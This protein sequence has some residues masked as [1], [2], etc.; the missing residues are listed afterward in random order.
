MNEDF[1][2]GDHLH[3]RLFLMFQQQA[4]FM[5]LLNE[6]RD[7]PE[8]PVNITDKKAQQQCRDIVHCTVEE[9][10]EAL[11]H[12][13]N[14]KKHRATDVPQVD[15]AEFIEEVVDAQHF[16]FELMLLVGVTPME[17]YQAFIQK[18]V[19]NEKRINEGY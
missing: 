8:F 19:I 13:K 5:K 12:L 17:F 15:R 14:W 4:G 2:P 1:P 7:F 10:F 11:R 18:G 3:D 9:L 6:K 16:L